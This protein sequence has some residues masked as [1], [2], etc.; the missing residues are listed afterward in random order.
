MFLKIAF[1][2]KLLPSLLYTP[3]CSTFIY[4]IW[5]PLLAK[6]SFKESFEVL[7]NLAVV[8]LELPTLRGWKGYCYHFSSKWDSSTFDIMKFAVFSSSIDQNF[9][10]YSPKLTILEINP[11]PIQWSLY[12]WKETY[13][14]L[15]IKIPTLSFISLQQCR[16]WKKILYRINIISNSLVFVKQCL[17]KNTVYCSVSVHPDAYICVSVS[18]EP[19][20]SRIIQ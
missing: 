18:Q 13:I 7:L 8:I 14:E 2:S 5:S 19:E 16:Q 4:N 9:I 1:V 20:T 15:H 10:I 11:T 3:Y 12:F 6:D 17:W